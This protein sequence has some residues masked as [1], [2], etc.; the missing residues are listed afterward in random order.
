MSVKYFSD[1]SG[2]PLIGDD[3]KIA[4]F[5]ISVWANHME[6]PITFDARWDLTATEYQAMGPAWN[7]FT[8]IV[9]QAV[10]DLKNAVEN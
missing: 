4:V 10:I 2:D 6:D 3:H 5:R 8:N 9:T 1:K 7:Q